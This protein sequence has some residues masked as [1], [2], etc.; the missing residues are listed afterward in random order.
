MSLTEDDIACESFTVIYIDYLL[1]Y[2]KRYY[3]KVY[4]ENC[5]HKIINKKMADY[6]HE[7]LFENYLL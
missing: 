1:V 2:D 3:L 5:A 6:L 4:L 7:N